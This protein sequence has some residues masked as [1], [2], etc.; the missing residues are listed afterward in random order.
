MK[1]CDLGGYKRPISNASMKDSLCQPSITEDA[2]TT[3]MGRSGRRI[4]EACG[5]NFVSPRSCC[6]SHLGNGM[7]FRNSTAARNAAASGRT[8]SRRNATCVVVVRRTCRRTP[9]E[10]VRRAT[11][12]DAVAREITSFGF[13][14]TISNRPS[15]GQVVAASLSDL[16]LGNEGSC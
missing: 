15:S 16:A 3:E 4:L 9:S 10:D 13:S 11:M 7:Q 6:R 2:T 5:S 12:N 8:C 1:L 14:T